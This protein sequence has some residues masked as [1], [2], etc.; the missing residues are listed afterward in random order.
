MGPGPRGKIKAAL[1]YLEV[2][3]TVVAVARDLDLGEPETTLPGT[4]RDPDMLA[5]LSEEFGLSSAVER[6]VQTLAGEER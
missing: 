1:D 6:L 5:A 3:P 4:P 2:A